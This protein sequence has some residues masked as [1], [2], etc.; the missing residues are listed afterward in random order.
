MDYEKALEEV[1][2]ALVELIAENRAVPVIVEGKKDILALRK[3]G[4]TGEIIRYNRGMGISDFCDMI[5]ANY[6]HVIILTDWDRKGGMLCRKIT[7]NLESRVHC[8]TLYREIFS[9]HSMIRT[10][11]GLP[12]WLET[13]K[14]K[15]PSSD[16]L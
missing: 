10:V 6:T 5:V 1:E 2:K 15:K 12:S 9:R 16:Q 11:E 8:N 13:L 14:Y 3:L 7:Q 4:L